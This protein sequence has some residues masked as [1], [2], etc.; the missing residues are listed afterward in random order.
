MAIGFV[1]LVPIVIWEV[2]PYFLSFSTQFHHSKP[3]LEAYAAKVM[4]NGPAVLASPPAKL[5]YFHVLKMEPLPNGF[6]FQSDYG[7]PFDW[8]GIAYS[9]T[10]L[11]DYDKDARG[12]TKQIFKPIEGNWYEVFRP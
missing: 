11:P 2:Y 4:A 8:D 3:A 7:N 10:P 12:E 6:L 1:I 9:T 5:G